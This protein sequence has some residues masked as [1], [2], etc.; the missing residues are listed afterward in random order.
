M[1]WIWRSS[2]DNMSLTIISDYLIM[3]YHGYRANIYCLLRVEKVVVE[4]Y[5]SYQVDMCEQKNGFNPQI[6]LV[7]I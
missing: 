3:S 7:H 1:T 5:E 2:P 6:I 4:Q